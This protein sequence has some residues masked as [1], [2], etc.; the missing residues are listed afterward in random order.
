MNLITRLSDKQVNDITTA[1]SAKY[2]SMIQ[3]LQDSYNTQMKK[4]VQTQQTQ[5]QE[6]NEIKKTHKELKEEVDKNVNE[7]FDKHTEMFS[8]LVDMI[9]GM[10][11]ADDKYR[12][13]TK[14]NSDSSHDEE[15][16]GNKDSLISSDTD[17]SYSADESDK[18]IDDNDITTVT[19]TPITIGTTL[20]PPSPSTVKSG[21]ISS[22]RTCTRH[23]STS[24][25]TPPCV[26]E[27]KVESD[28]QNDIR[29]VTLSSIP[30]KSYA[31][32]E[33]GWNNITGN[34]RKATRIKHAIISPAKIP[35]A[36]LNTKDSPNYNRYLPESTQRR[37]NRLKHKTG[38]SAS[39]H[40]KEVISIQE[41]GPST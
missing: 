28:D 17:I 4:L 31:H 39:D 16:S 9:K 12:E 35:K 32:Q 38:E 1:V 7:K 24:K 13:R 22:P 30:P 19:T 25:D 29:K 18:E 41:S 15:D 40:S 37:S 2:D 11:Q 5:E 20:T 33:V 8:S 34:M 6:I 14:N 27:N 26:H 3:Q 10:R 21:T 23:S 36:Q